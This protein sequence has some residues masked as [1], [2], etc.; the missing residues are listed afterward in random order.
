MIIF[1]FNV[2][3]HGIILSGIWHYT[4]RVVKEYAIKYSNVYIVTGPV[5]D[6]NNDGLFDVELTN[7]TK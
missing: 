4:W 3:L 1:E 7:K 6:Y 5:Y 2:F